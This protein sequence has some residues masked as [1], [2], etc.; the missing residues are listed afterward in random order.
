[1]AG[2]SRELLSVGIDIG[3][4][5]SQVV[6]SR[7]ALRQAARVG[8]VPRFEVDATS[9]LYV[10]PT[11]CTPLVGP[12]EVD[13]DA[14]AALVAGEYAAAG[15]DRAKVETGAVI[16]TGEAARTHN[17]DALLTALADFAGEFVVTVAGPNLEAQIAGRGSGAASY[18]ADRYTQVTNLDIGGGTTNAAVFRMGEHLSS[19]AMAVGGRQLE[20]EAASQVVRRLAPPGAAIVAAT[21]LPIV[22]GQ[23]VD[24]HA[25]RRF[26]DVMADLVVDLLE[27]TESDLG[28]AV[29]LTPPLRGAAASTATFLSGGVARC[30]YEG[31]PASSVT[32]VAAYGDVGPL[33]AQSLRANRRLQQ[34]TVRRPPET[35]RATVLGAATQTVALSGSTIWTDREVLPLRNL[36]VVTPHLDAGVLHPDALADALRQAVARWDAA[37]GQTVAVVLEI[38]PRLPYEDLTTIAKGVA[39]YAADLPVTA[40]LVLVTQHDYAQVLG[41]TLQAFLPTTP[42]VVVDQVGLGE[43]D[44][45]DIG[46]PVMGG[47]VVP[48]SVKTLVFY[49]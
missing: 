39:A 13:V 40:P 20:I 6:F 30:Y 46:T 3:T 25:L 37:G 5:T 11:H 38:P 26:C 43:G 19:S 16:I 10:G 35:I 18:S 29:S 31:T 42:L 34:H 44:V 9:L 2:T 4:T 22:V 8:Q 24:L 14:L 32:E 28:R 49:R 27:G 17:A 12:D 45:I 36:P 41:Q 1:M 48:L 21:G 47:R 23:A 33:L 15:I 7:L